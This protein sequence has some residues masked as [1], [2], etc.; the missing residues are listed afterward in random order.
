MISSSEA[1]AGAG[2][3]EPGVLPFF[4]LLCCPFSERAGCEFSLCLFL[5]SCVFQW[6]ED[7]GYGCGEESV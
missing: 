5:H 1:E 7:A 3:A 6:P 4:G 2:V